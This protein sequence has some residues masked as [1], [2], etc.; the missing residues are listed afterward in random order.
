MFSKPHNAPNFT[1]RSRN[2]VIESGELDWS[3]INPDIFGSMIQ[4]VIT[5]EHRGGLGMHYTS[6]P[7]IMK[8][9]EPLFL[10]ELY[11]EFEAAK[12][13]PRGLNKL[14]ERIG[15]IKIFDPACGSGNFLIISYKELRLLEIKILQQLQTFQ[16]VASGFEPNHL[17][18][19][20][21]AQ[22]TLAAAFQ[23]PMFSRIEL[24]N[25]YGIELDD[26][27][28]EIAILSLWLA[29]HQMNMKFKEAFGTGNPT[30]PLKEGG[31]ITQ[32]NATRIEWQKVCPK[33]ENDEIY[34]LGNPPYLGGKLLDDIQKEDTDIIFNGFDN[35][36]NLDYI[37][38]WFYK[39]A[40]Y[41]TKNIKVAFVSTNSISQGTQV[42]DLWPSI[43]N[44]NIEIFF[45]NK[46]FQWSNNA[47]NKA[48]VI[49]SII[50]LREK[51]ISP[52]Y[53]FSNG[54][55]YQVKNI[56]GYLSNAANIF[57]QKR[58]IPLSNLP[59]MNQ[60]NIPLDS[61]Y[62]MFND[63]EREDIIKLYPTTN[64]LFKKVTGS[65]ESINN[66]VRWCLW[67]S[68]NNLPLALSIPPL[69]E[70]IDKVRDFRIK[71]GTN[72]KSCANRPHQFCMVNNAKSA[73]I[74]I[75]IV[76]SERRDYIPI[77]Y[78]DSDFIVIHSAY[79]IYDP[80]L[81]IFGLINSA[82]HLLWVKTFSGKLKNDSR[83]S[84]GLCWYSFPFP[85]I[86][87]EQKQELERNVYQ[88]LSEREKHSEKTLA[89]LYDPDKMPNGLREAHHH[90]DLAVERCYRS[91]PFL[92]DDERL[93]Y[94]FKL[95]EQMIA[96]EKERNGELNFEPVKPK[97][98][99][100]KYA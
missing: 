53:I 98:K 99:K 38:C 16:K 93:E 54:I 91:K 69:K 4:A 36:Y 11:E 71:G 73:Q 39:A 74:V 30:L 33:K 8:V 20:P 45:A 56:N 50:G 27:A 59:I 49:C 19:I 64:A 78:F 95:Y 22:L 51:S 15:I 66:L 89:Q 100:K 31:H 35:Y 42:F 6:V 10:T 28:H 23:R 21:K 75:P 58:T 5:P 61:G 26:F 81:Y 60:G 2:V 72:A 43:F 77:S 3:A 44:K 47:K 86:N 82:I 70:R 96:E 46:N 63:I 92:N 18:L 85:E 55:K 41:I 97:T 40:L 80:E 13:D 7:N 34:V 12:Y 88:V 65:V 68:E 62:L 48:A 37:A 87:H 1:R 29:Q 32:G 9:I 67:L 57:V 25:F 79:V 84:V 94:L 17:E 52:K 14:L 24:E 83:Y 76:S 90:L